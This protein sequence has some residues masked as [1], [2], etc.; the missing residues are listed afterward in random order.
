M[1][2]EILRYLGHRPIPITPKRLATSQYSGDWSSP[3]TGKGMDFRSHRA[4]ELG[5]DPRSIN[6]P[7]SVRAGKRMVVERIARRDISIFV[8]IDCSASM[9][10]RHKADMLM[11][12]ALM[13]L[14]SG[15]NMEM[16]IGAALLTGNGY[17][18]LGIGMGHRH[19]MRLFD[20]VEQACDAT[21][22]GHEL[23][24]DLM[25][26]GLYRFLPTGCIL[27]Y[28]SDFLDE[29]GYPQ[30]ILPF[31]LNIT[32][33]D[34]IPVVIQDEFEYSFPVLPYSSLLEL[35]NPETD[36]IQP[37]WFDRSECE[38]INRIHHGRFTSITEMFSE[39]GL[40]YVHIENPDLESVHNSLTRFFAYR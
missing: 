22:Q 4:Y 2:S 33:Y 25:H 28:L 8:L 21:R 40:N 5:D 30:P 34:F 12:T 35:K 3:Y 1:R 14:Y 27:F 32:R 11:K 15:I 24:L 13:L 26:R 39:K 38:L 29:R 23:D 37:V 17:H 7:M 9:G 36:E 19:A 20:R 31:S 10:V 18:S 6:M 16:R